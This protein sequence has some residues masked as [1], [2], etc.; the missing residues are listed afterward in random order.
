VTGYASD[1]TIGY[2]FVRR[3]TTGATGSFQ[4]VD[5]FNPA[6]VFNTIGRFI[7][8]DSNDQVYVA[9]SAANAGDSAAG[10]AQG[11]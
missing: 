11:R 8:V 5:T 10:S 1:K 7:A 6:Q 4:T 9:G 2:W 3:S